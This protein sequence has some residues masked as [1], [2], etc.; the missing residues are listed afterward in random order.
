MSRDRANYGSTEPRVLV[1][2][3]TSALVGQPN[4][5]PGACFDRV[6]GDLWIGDVGQNQIGDDQSRHMAAVSTLAGRL[7]KAQPAQGQIVLLKA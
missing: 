6:T 5:I 7:W 2:P 3:I 4:A 1:M